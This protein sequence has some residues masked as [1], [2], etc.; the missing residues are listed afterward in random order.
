MTPVLGTYIVYIIGHKTKPHKIPMI[1]HSS[2]KFTIE[3]IPLVQKQNLH[4]P[5][6]H[7]FSHLLAPCD[8][9]AAYRSRKTGSTL[10]GA[11]A[12]VPSRPCVC[13]STS[14]G[15]K[16][17]SLKFRQVNHTRPAY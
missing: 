2:Q 14:T 11:T 5:P 9:F 8:D 10:E 16:E 4:H 17:G 13:N 7:R 3:N 1:M 12:F 6:K 15:K